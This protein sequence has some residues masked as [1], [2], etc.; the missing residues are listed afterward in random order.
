ML[1]QVFL[2]NGSRGKLR[3]V[4][5]RFIGNVKVDGEGRDDY[6]T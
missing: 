3:H 5:L 2:M 6:V 1:G 4:R